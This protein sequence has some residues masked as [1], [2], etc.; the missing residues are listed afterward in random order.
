MPGGQIQGRTKIGSSLVYASFVYMAEETRD[1]GS[2]LFDW[3]KKRHGT[4]RSRAI[5][6]L[7]IHT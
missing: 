7:L 5:D 3:K 6:V 4:T 2:F 1:W